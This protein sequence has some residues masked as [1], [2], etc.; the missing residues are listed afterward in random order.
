MILSINNITNGKSSTFVYRS[1]IETKQPANRRAGQL[2]NL[3]HRSF[4]NYAD[5]KV[6]TDSKW[7]HILPEI[8]TSE[9][10]TVK[11]STDKMTQLRSKLL[12]LW[13]GSSISISR[14]FSNL[15]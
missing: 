8:G 5:F 10:K 1:W 12:I 2:L 7:K 4:F 9:V 14:T 11:C 3:D 15:F 13:V 6:Y